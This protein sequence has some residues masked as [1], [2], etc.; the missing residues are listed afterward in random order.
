DPVVA[1]VLVAVDL[2]PGE[3]VVVRALQE[4]HELVLDGAALVNADVLPLLL[5][6]DLELERVVR[7]HRRN[8]NR[9]PI[10]F[11]ICTGKHEHAHR[12]ERTREGKRTARARLRASAGPG[13]QGLRRGRGRARG[14]SRGRRR[15]RERVLISA[16]FAWSADEL[17]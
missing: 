14:A 13:A 1:D 10:G 8:P 2:D 9:S 16:M 6:D 5:I 7:R 17:D 12:D 3:L 11:D 4:V 15:G